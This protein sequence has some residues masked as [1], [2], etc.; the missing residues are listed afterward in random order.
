M[1]ITEI[2]PWDEN[3]FTGISKIDEQ[4]RQ[5][6]Y[7][8]NLL[9]SHLSHQSD[10][11]LLND[12]FNQ[13]TEYAL[14][15]FQTEE[16]IWHEYL[17][18]DAWEEDHKRSHES[19]IESVI[20]LKTENK[21]KPFDKVAEDVLLLLTQW[22]VYHI[23]DTD[24]RMAK[25]VL[26]M[27]SG[28]SLEVAKQQ[29]AHETETAMKVLI[30]TILNMY[31]ILSSR[32]LQLSREVNERKLA[33]AKLRLA[34]AAFDTTLDGICIMDSNTMVIEANTAFS[35]SIPPSLKAFGNSLKDLKSGFK[36]DAFAH[37]VWQA[38]KKAGH[39]CG[40]IRSIVETEEEESEWLTLSM[41]SNIQGAAI[42]YVG[43]FSNIRH[44]LK[45]QQNLQQIA[46]HDALTG[47]PNRLFLFDRMQ[48]AIAN[49]KRS[50]THLAVCYM[51][52]DGFKHVNDKLGHAAGDHVLKE[53]SHRLQSV[54]R[55]NDTVARLGG[56]E[57][58][59]LLGELKAPT[60]YLELIDRALK[61]IQQPIQIGDQIAR[62]SASIG[63]TIY[64]ADDSNAETLL[65]HA[66]Q[67]MYEA[68]RLG[69]SRHYLWEH[70]AV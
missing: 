53:I 59:M 45:F 44:L 6:V 39:W 43:V 52:L 64:P 60:D 12:V 11:D 41:I 3:F 31:E 18:Q 10:F 21:T 16:A 20:N 27:Q 48:L 58:V 66:D 2:F 46:L 50:Q 15:H 69:K 55:A 36:D 42:N 33:E 13:L 7:L 4:H 1:Q 25:V 63:L 65:K 24:M 37:T 23:L 56:D 30:Q 9:A 26:R 8:L 51:D 14:Y 38:V 70:E 57:F 61:V 28:A 68:K 32:S 62:V 67:A 54:V 22:L 47:L 29:S 34:G 49:S 40:E 17:P 19:F 5:L 35:Q